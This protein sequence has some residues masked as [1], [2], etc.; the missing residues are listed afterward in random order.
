[1]FLLQTQLEK[2]AL[3]S[4]FLENFLKISKKKIGEF[5]IFPEFYKFF[6]FFLEISKQLTLK[7]FL[8]FRTLAGSGRISQ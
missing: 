2:I 3:Q 1:M 8:F 6:G 7:K 5:F 4:D